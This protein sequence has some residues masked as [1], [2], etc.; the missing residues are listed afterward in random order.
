MRVDAA[1]AAYVYYFIQR[2]LLNE[3]FQLRFLKNV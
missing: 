2:F 3:F 1:E